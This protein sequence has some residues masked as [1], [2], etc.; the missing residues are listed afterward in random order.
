[1]PWENGY[2]LPGAPDDPVENHPYENFRTDRPFELIDLETS[3]GSPLKL[4]GVR[5]PATAHAMINNEYCSFWLTRDGDP[6]YRTQPKFDRLLSNAS[7]EQ[8]LEF[9]AYLLGG[10]TEYWRA[11]RNFAAVLH[12]VLLTAS[13]RDLVTS[14][15]FRDVTTLEMDPHLRAM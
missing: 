13:S 3:A 5:T 9:Y 1:M 12:F 4:D 11:H 10:L 8:R 7:R 14:D 2:N 15:S 6:T